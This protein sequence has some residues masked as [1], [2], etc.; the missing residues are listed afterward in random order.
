MKIFLLINMINVK[1]LT[2]KNCCW[3]FKIQDQDKFEPRCEK[4]GLREFPTRSDKNR[5]QALDVWTDIFF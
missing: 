4:T 2:V 3:Q 1:M 5:A